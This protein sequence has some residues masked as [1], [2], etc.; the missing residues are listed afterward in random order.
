VTFNSVDGGGGEKVPAE[1]F[2]SAAA[3]KNFIGGGGE[4]SAANTSICKYCFRNS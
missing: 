3:D 4:K 1:M 2:Y